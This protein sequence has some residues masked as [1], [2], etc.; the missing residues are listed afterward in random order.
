M[1]PPE[2]PKKLLVIG[3]GAIGIEFASFYNDMGADVTVVE[4]LDRIV[5]GYYHRL[6]AQGRIERSTCCD[7]T[8]TEH[9]MMGKLMSDSMLMWTQQYKLDS[10]RFDLMGHQPRQVMVDIQQRLQ[11]ELNAGAKLFTT[12]MGRTVTWQA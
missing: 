11:V 7:N 10:F 5:P 6:D 1:V 3:S 12:R 4:M 9:L 8:A 2:M